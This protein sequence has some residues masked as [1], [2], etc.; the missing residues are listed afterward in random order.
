MTGFN[1]GMQGEYWKESLKKDNEFIDYQPIKRMGLALD[2]ANAALFLASDM[3][4]FI[5]GESIPVNGGAFAI[6]HNQAWND[7]LKTI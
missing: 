5:S 7:W 4:S 3:S 1:I 6:G 2:I